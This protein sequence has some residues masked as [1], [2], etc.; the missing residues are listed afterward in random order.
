M[1]LHSSSL[2]SL[3]YTRLATRFPTCLPIKLTR[4]FSAPAPSS[5]ALSRSPIQR[6]IFTYQTPLSPS[7]RTAVIYSLP[8]RELSLAGSPLH[9]KSQRSCRLSLVKPTK[10]TPTLSQMPASRRRW[11]TRPRLLFSLWLAAP[12]LRSH[13]YTCACL[14]WQATT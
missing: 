11:T 5:P 14:S 6:H 12:S 10:W 13:S 8:G 4:D 9:P 3:L 2:S 1:S 7:D